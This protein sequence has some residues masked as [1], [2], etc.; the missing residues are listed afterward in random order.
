MHFCHKRTLHPDPL[1]TLNSVNIPIVTETKFRGLFFDNKL[2][3]IPH[4]KYIQ[5]KCLRSMNLLRIVAHMDWGGDR[6]TLLRLYRCLIRTKLD[7][8]CIVYGAAR[9]SYISM[10]DPVQNQALR[11]CL[12]A[13][14]TSPVES[15]QVEANEPSLAQRRNKLS[16]L[17]ALRLASNIHNPV[18]DDVFFPR[19]QPLFEKRPKTV[20]TFGIRILRQFRD[21]D[22][23]PFT[24]AQFCH[25]LVPAWIC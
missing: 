16:V 18:Y 21:I 24:V 14:R 6:Q 22:I 4:L 7:Y 17:Y 19:Y 20:P 13:F 11:V 12:V 5:A 9:K 3:Y 1:L 25:P 8:G 23:D 2:S 10:L 15:L